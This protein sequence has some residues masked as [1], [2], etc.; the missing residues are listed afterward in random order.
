MA[1]VDTAPGLPDNHR[2]EPP[3]SSLSTIPDPRSASS[4]NLSETGSASSRHPDLSNEVAALSDKLINAINHQTTL[5]DTLAQTRH[6]LAASRA[7]IEELEAEAK[8]HE[9]KLASG[10]L[11]AKDDVDGEKSR[12]LAD[13]AD[14]RKQKTLVQQEKRGIEAELENLTA[15]LF[16]E[17]NKMVASAN[18]ERE[19]MERK[20]QQLRDQIKDTEQL[21]ASQHEQLLELKTVMQHMSVEGTKDAT[22]SPQSS[23][24]PTSPMTARED[25][26]ITRLLEAMNLSPATP[27]ADDVTPA[28][29]T[30]F[31]YLLKAVCRTD[32]PAYEDFRHLIVTSQQSRPASRVASGN[33]NGL[34]VMGLSSLSNTH[35]P[36]K[37]ASSPSLNGAPNFST[38][39]HLPGSF[40]PTATEAKGPIP[41]KE[42]KFFKRLLVEDIEPA[43]RLDL[44]PSISWLSRRIIIAALIEGS[45]VVEPIPESHRRLYGRYTSCSMC[46]ESRKGDENP[47]THRMKVNEGEGA[48]KWPLC[49]LCLE[50]VRG[51]GDLVSYVRMIR[52]GVVKCHEKEEELE[53][54]DELVRLRERLFWARMAGG[55]VPAFLRSEKNSP[56]APDNSEMQG[57]TNGDEE[58][59]VQELPGKFASPATT[60]ER[61]DSG[62]SSA[63]NDTQDE[64]DQ[65]LRRGLD[66]ST[67]PP[68]SGIETRISEPPQTPSPLPKRESGSLLKVKVPEAFWNGQVNVLH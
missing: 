62:D 44:S 49:L 35:P 1:A 22:A 58:L 5:D 46:G 39:P 61:Q 20:N 57:D 60:I 19:A 29:S 25:N 64:V 14:E 17:A 40:S 27:G 68:R 11:L 31:A 21:L 24:A 33:Y 59:Q 7:R 13:L 36:S 48:T 50:K 10:Q 42:T 54:W 6:E 16:E 2:Q 43:L 37:N 63:G 52:D 51:A 45:M 41:L 4:S 53:A 23:T 12:L 18:M 38:T 56:I 30:T 3:E 26:S 28:P 15:S 66:E 47:R 9:E 55:V 34:N 8:A 32:L 65:Q 67:T